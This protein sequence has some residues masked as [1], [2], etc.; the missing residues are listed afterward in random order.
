MARRPKRAD[1]D[2][3]DRWLVSYADFIT[4]LFAFFVVMY[5]ISSVN[6]GKYKVLSTSI[7]SAFSRMALPI[8][9]DTRNMDQDELLKNLVDRRN[10]RIAKQQLKQQEY[11]KN[12]LD[13]LNR[14]L[15]PLVSKGQVSVIQSGRGIVLDL[16][17]RALFHEGDATLQPNAVKTLSE[18]AQVLKPGDLAI[19][20]EGHTDNVPINTAQYPSNW[21]LS[22]ARASSVV[23]LFIKEGVDSKR[24][25]AAGVADNQPL[26]ANDTPEHRAKNRRVTVTI[27]TPQVSAETTDP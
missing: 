25:T 12:L 24:L 21:E 20:V 26:V 23:R 19:Q 16:N 5:A 27:L 2:N 11:M 17:V 14:V 6:E 18:V 7:N 15:A 10:A 4:L 1:R 13:D 22:S 3:N 8:E 9:A